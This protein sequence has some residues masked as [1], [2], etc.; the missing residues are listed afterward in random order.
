MTRIAASTLILAAVM[1]AAAAPAATPGQINYQGL[2]LDDQGQPVTGNVDLVFR[3]FTAAQ[4]GTA[5]WTEAHPDVAALDGVYD[6]VLGATTPITP[7]MIAGDSLYL[8]IAVEGE[9]LTPRQRLVAVPYAL[10]AAVADNVGNVDVGYLA[11]IVQNVDFDGGAPANDDPREGLADPD[12]DGNANFI[13]SDNDNDGLLDTAELNQDSDINLVTPTIADIQPEPVEVSLSTLVTVTGTNFESGIAVSFGSQSP[14]PQNLTSTSFQVAVGPQTAGTKTVTVTRTNGQS[15][16]TTFQ[17]ATNQP[18]IT[19]F[20]PDF[21]NAGT[22]GTITIH[23][24]G[25]QAGI[26]VT[27]GSESPTPQNITA[28]SLQV[29]VSPQPAGVVT[30]TVF[31]PGPGGAST[32]ADFSFVDASQPKRVFVTSTTYN[33]NLGGILGANAKCAARAAAASLSGSYFAWLGDATGDPASSFSQSPQPYYLVDG[34]T[35]VAG[36]FTSLT[37]GN[38]DH[39]IDRDEFGAFH[40]DYVWTNVNTNG[41]AAADSC[42]SWSS[43]SGSQNGRVGNSTETDQDWTTAGNLPCSELRRLY[44]FQQ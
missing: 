27:F 25:F 11:Q 34:T 29:A 6:A 38:I 42:Q 7:A 36:S 22:G 4:G 33:A 21:L 23:G 39:A 41:T 30:V 32:S 2:L 14:T 43:A 3:L 19:A 10:R 16:S 40:F 35:L 9:T 8:E 17:F 26:A 13:D 15:A 44:C 1:L 24:S 20:D 28:T 12:G 31:Y 5:L 37:D 18:V